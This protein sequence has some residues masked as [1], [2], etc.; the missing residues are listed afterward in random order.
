MG[1]KT[2][3]V[4]R[5]ADARWGGGGMPFELRTSLQKD[6]AG[7]GPEQPVDQLEGSGFAGS[8]APQQ[9]Q[10]FARG[11]LE[12]HAADDLTVIKRIADISQFNSQAIGSRRSAHARP[13][14]TGIRLDAMGGY[15]TLL[16]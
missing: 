8:A 13:W 15:V 14:T 4:N 12:S 10:C 5:V 9:N 16:P 1:E 11:H 6:F 2:Q 7:R 3:G